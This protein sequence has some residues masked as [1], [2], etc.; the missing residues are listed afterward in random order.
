M[1]TIVKVSRNTANAPACAFSSQS[2]AFSH[3]NNISAQLP[4]SSQTG[5]L[6]S[7]DIK[8][9]TKQCLTN[10][11][12]IVESIDHV[13][14]DVVK[15]NVYIKNMADIDA[16]NTVYNDFFNGYL[17]TQTTIAVAALPVEGAHIQ[18]DAL[19][20]NGEGTPPQVACALESIV[21]NAK[22]APLNSVSTHTVAFSHYNNL[23]AQ[24]PIDPNTGEIVAGG[25]KEQTRQCL[26]NVKTVLDS[27]NVPFDDIVKV[28]IFVKT[29]SDL[30]AVNEAYA[31]F[32]P[33]SAIAR[34]HGY[35]PAR[36]VIAVP[37]LKLGASVQIDAVVSHGDGTPPQATEDRH[38]IVIKA[39]N[40]NKAP[41]D[42]MSTQTV[43]FSH[44]NHLS[45]QLPVDPDNN[46]LIAGN[47]EEQAKQCLKHLQSIVESIGHEMDDIVKVNI[48]LKNIN[49]LNLINGIYKSFFKQELPSRT[50]YQVPEIT[51]GALI[52][53]DAVVSNA[54]G[55]AP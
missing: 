36:S 42:S 33:C 21:N 34:R 6:V 27:I 3:Y 47:V 2:V 50:V 46:E 38:G 1:S 7:D 29:L 30:N 39:N 31:S 28:N 18:M 44:Y 32:F 24:L 45:A 19:L 25:V 48:Q 41:R 8:A 14:D 11:K 35:L 16:V 17:P 55:T 5:I 9:Q 37:D 52:Q 22:A 4:I 12:A 13:M 40:T 43:A 49:D 54:E 10:I 51:K 15:I 23:S 53:I 20:S 26:T